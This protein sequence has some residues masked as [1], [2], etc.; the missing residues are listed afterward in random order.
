M[1][2]KLKDLVFHPEKV[3]GNFILE[4]RDS[5]HNRFLF[6]ISRRSTLEYFLEPFLS[7]FGKI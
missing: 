2:R 7:I 5:H 6:E 3:F 1:S 4:H